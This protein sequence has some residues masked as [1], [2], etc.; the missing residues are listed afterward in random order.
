MWKYLLARIAEPSTW[1]GLAVH[2]ATVQ[3]AVATHNPAAIVAAA[4]GV[5]AAVLPESKPAGA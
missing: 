1:A 5:V 2:A 3:A 4:A